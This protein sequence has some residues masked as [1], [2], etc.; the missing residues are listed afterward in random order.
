MVDL[1]HTV[2][3]PMVLL[4]RGEDASQSGQDN[5]GQFCLTG[6]CKDSSRR[7]HRLN[8]G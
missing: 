3:A 1:T 2:S 4:V 6:S 8:V 7:G 5:E